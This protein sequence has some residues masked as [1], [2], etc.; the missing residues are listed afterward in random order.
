MTL[1]ISEWL[2]QGEELARNIS[3]L[4]EKE[5]IQAIFTIST[6]AKMRDKNPP[7]FSPTRRLHN[8]FVA[9]AIVYSQT[10]ALLLWQT[11]RG[12]WYRLEVE[13]SSIQNPFF[14]AF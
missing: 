4:A 10:Q 9:G 5:N 2:K 14:L 11:N 12:I 8:G 3:A 13:H 1:N 7:F 6:T